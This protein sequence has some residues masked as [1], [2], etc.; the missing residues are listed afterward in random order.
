MSASLIILSVIILLIMFGA[1]QKILDSLRLN[2]RTA[3]LILVLIC[4]GL[5]IPPIWIG[6]YFCFS[7]GGYLIPL[8]LSIYLLIS[9]GWS[10]DLLRA[11]VGSLLVGGIIY[12]LE[13]I[14]PADPEEM[15]IDNMYIYGIVAGLV[16]YIL[17]RSRRNAF[18][19]CLFGLTLAQVIQWVI[20]WNKGTPTILGLGVGGAFGT[21]IV[22]ILI[23]V[24]LSEFVGRCIELIVSKSNEKEYN[25]K[26]HAYDSVKNGKKDSLTQKDER[27]QNLVTVADIESEIEQ[28]ADEKP[29]ASA[30]KKSAKSSSGKLKSGKN[31]AKKDTEVKEKRVR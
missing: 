16:A 11:V 27:E 14:M 21:Y 6:K 10:T 18:V 8:A 1:G 2:D 17:G 15:L 12:A 29:I 25:F 31:Y 19:S 20:N 7:I 5:I 22:S 28:K 4:I 9:C 30:H 13:W 26:T 23:A 3:L 24:A